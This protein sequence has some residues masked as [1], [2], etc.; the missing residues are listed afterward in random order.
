MIRLVFLELL[1]A[2]R[3]WVGTLVLTTVTGFVSALALALVDTGLSYGGKVSESLASGGSA[4]LVFSGIAA[5]VVLSANSN[6]AVA[7]QQRNYALWQLV[8]IPPARIGWVVLAQLAVVGVVGS[9]LGVLAAAFVADPVYAWGFATWEGLGHVVYRVG[10]LSLWLTVVIVTALTVLGGLRGARRASRVP[11]IEALRSSEPPSMKFGWVRVCALVLSLTVT[12]S[13]ATGLAGES[14]AVIGSKAMFLAPCL[15]AVFAAL[16][17]A[18]FPV[19]LRLWTS[20]LPKRA[21]AT[22]FLA[23]SSAVYRLSQ[24]SAAIS[25]LMVAIAIAAGLYATGNT[26]NAAAA[27]SSGAAAEWSIAL[28]GFVIVLGGPLLISCCAAAATVFM[29]GQA[30]DRESALIRAAGSTQ[31][32]ALLGAT[33]EA[34]IYAVSATILGAGAVVI[35]GLILVGALNVQMAPRFALDVIGAIAAA[36]FVLLLGATVMPTALALRREIPRVLAAE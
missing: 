17:P 25:P 10:P 4:V 6:L 33:W 22:W 2:A 15:A 23:R 20:L 18:L 12:I 14:Y 31:R 19:L 34:V 1:A 36:G 27:V 7:L 9:L 32:A 11:A 28:E 13:L 29:T 8:G 30:R 16:G 5:V 35:G 24:S 3:I 26:L 21:S